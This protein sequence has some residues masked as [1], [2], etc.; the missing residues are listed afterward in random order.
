[1]N[2]DQVA[3]GW[4]SPAGSFRFE[5][6]GKADIL[7]RIEVID[8]AHGIFGTVTFID[9]LEAGTGIETAGETKA[10]IVNS[11]LTRFDSTAC[12]GFGFSRVVDTAAGTGIFLSLI[13]HAKG[14]V[15][16]TGSDQIGKYLVFSSHVNL[17]SV[18]LN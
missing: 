18:K 4:A 5:E 8:E 11:F 14:A 7:Y 6:M 16:P 12:T 17:P 13:N 1:M 15:H 10:G 3:T 9:L 2:T